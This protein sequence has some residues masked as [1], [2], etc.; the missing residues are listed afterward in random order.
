MFLTEHSVH[1]N[2]LIPS[3]VSEVV[4][5]LMVIEKMFLGAILKVKKKK[6]AR[7]H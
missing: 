3:A 6:N 2:M 5:E 4:I 7:E 1:S